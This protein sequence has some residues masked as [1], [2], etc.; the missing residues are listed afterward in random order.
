MEFKLAFPSIILLDILI[1]TYNSL[2]NYL[3][4]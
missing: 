1:N 2:Y 3:Q 4:I